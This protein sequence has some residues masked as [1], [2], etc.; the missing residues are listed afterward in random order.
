MSEAP[1]HSDSL[2]TASSAEINTEPSEVWSSLTPAQQDTV[3]Q[4]LV[5]LIV[6]FII[7]PAAPPTGDGT[8]D[9]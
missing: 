9:C 2:A 1:D 8:D 6:R 5:T 3:T 4:Q 7:L